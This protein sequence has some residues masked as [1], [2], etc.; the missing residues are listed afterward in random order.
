[1]RTDCEEDRAELE[2]PTSGD[3]ECTCHGGNSTMEEREIERAEVSG[4]K[5]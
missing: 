2:A 5:C 1:M 3:E 4:G